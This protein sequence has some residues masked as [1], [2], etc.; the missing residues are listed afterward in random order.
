MQNFGIGVDIESVS[1]FKK[2]GLDIN[3]LFL[4]KIFTKDELEFCFSK[5]NYAQHLAARF[6]GKE[7][8]IKALGS[9]GKEVAD[10]YA[11]EILNNE[12]GVP[13]VKI[14]SPNISDVEVYISLSHCKDKA[15][16]FVTVKEHKK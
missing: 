2:E 14:I 10:Y 12:K 8:V 11:I 9:M 13:M 15:L 4:N 3:S 1:R 5:K 6:A 16:S 7:A